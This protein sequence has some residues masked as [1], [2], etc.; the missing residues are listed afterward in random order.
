[1]LTHQD[2]HLQEQMGI[3]GPEMMPG[4]FNCA[5][6]RDPFLAEIDFLILPAGKMV[7][8]TDCAAR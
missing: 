6:C 7:C 4:D 1:M 5:Q 3:A 8:G 2:S